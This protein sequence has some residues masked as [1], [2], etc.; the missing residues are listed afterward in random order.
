MEKNKIEFDY[1][2]MKNGQPLD[3]CYAFAEFTDDDMEEMATALFEVNSVGEL[4]DLPEKYLGMFVDA[5]LDD[6]AEIYPDFADE[7]SGYSV[8][9]QRFLPDDMLD[10]LPDELIENFLPEM[11]EEAEEEAEEEDA[12]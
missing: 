11:F 8:M 1:L 3:D 10:F 4:T 2:I 6:A 12:E 5:A 9:L 7:K